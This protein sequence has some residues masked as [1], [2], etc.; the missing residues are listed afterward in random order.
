MISRNPVR[1]VVVETAPGVYAL[2]DLKYTTIDGNYIVHIDGECSD[3]RW[4]SQYVEFLEE[5]N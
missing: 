1:R 3:H 4:E 2:G 5:Y